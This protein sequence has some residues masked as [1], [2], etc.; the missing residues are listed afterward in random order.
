MVICKYYQQGTCKFGSNCRFEHPRSDYLASG[1]GAYRARFGAQQYTPNNNYY[2]QGKNTGAY[3]VGNSSHDFE[4]VIK[5]VI[6]EVVQ[7]EKGGQW[8]LTCFAPIKERACFP[9]WEDQSPEEIRSKMYEAHRNGTLPECKRQIKEL[10]EAARQRRQNILSPNNEV[11]KIIDKLLRGQ[12]I[13]IETSFSFVQTATQARDNNFLSW[14]PQGFSAGQ[15][16][17]QQQ[18][19]V[20]NNFVFALPQL[21]SSVQSTV[22]QPPSV[23]SGNT[24]AIPNVSVPSHNVFASSNEVPVQSP[25][26][27]VAQDTSR[28]QSSVQPTVPANVFVGDKNVFNSSPGWNK[29]ENTTTDT[30]VYT[31]KSELL[32]DEINAFVAQTFTVGKVPMK[33]PPK[34]L[35]T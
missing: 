17:Q 30:S 6:Q 9:G 21:N 23:F 1:E 12:K 31:P 24:Q 28:F 27:N 5:M 4:E 35:C 26:G 14:N 8:P 34:E 20:S 29:V 11:F 16:Q 18:P 25:F 15:Q 13:E 2:S 33:P 19:P 32:E 22:Q 7:M 3:K 10:Y